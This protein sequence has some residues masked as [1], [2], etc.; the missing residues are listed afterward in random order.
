MDFTTSASDA[1][2]FMNPL[3][4][5]GGADEAEDVIGA[6]ER[7]L[8]LPWGDEE[9]KL[10]F[11]CCDAPGHGR[12]LHDGLAQDSYPDGVKGQRRWQEVSPQP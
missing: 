10:I 5:S 1:T 3:R 2:A 9:V 7:V 11:H 8:Q 6:L 12:E 4:A